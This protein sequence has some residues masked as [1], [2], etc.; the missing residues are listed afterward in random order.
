[1]PR[2]CEEGCTCKKHTP[3]AER[4]AKIAAA[5]MGVSVHGGPAQGFYLMKGHRY[6]TGVW[7][8]P[9]SSKKGVVAEHRMVLYDTIGPGP[10]PCHWCG[11][12]LD[13]G[14][15]QGIQADHV[16]ED[17]LNNDPANIVPS[18]LHC[19]LW[20]NGGPWA[21]RHGRNRKEKTA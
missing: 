16:D 12:P 7:D 10:H 5:R 9:L 11:K 17:K 4:N 6:L 3:S 19:N 15:A 13:W 2:P 21:P 8:H 20:R 14:G 1:M 18:C